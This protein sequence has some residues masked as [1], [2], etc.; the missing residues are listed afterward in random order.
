MIKK[1]F[2]VILL[3]VAVLLGFAAIS[4]YAF[5]L[6]MT[7]QGKVELGDQ[8]LYIANVLTGLVGGIVA[9]GFGMSPKP[10]GSLGDTVLKRSAKG[11]GELMVKTAAQGPV[12][13]AGGGGGSKARQV[14]GFVYALIYILVGLAAIVIWMIDDQAA[15]LVKNL[16]TVFLGMAVPIVAAFFKEN[17]A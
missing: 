6:T 4:F 12:G 2:L 17:K 3:V 14:L 1:E 16:S 11:L 9:F 10:T 15:D 8:L 5:W 7:T 13:A